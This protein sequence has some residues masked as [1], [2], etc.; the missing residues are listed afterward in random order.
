MTEGR[1]NKGK[2]THPAGKQAFLALPFIV[3]ATCKTILCALQDLSP[4]RSQCHLQETG[5]WTV[6]FWVSLSEAQLAFPQCGKRSAVQD[7][8]WDT[9]GSKISCSPSCLFAICPSYS[10]MCW[11]GNIWTSMKEFPSLLLPLRRKWKQHDHLRRKE[12]GPLNQ[13]N[14]FWY[15]VQGSQQRQVCLLVLFCSFKYWKKT[16]N[17]SKW[18]NETFA[19]MLANTNVINIYV[20]KLWWHLNRC[21]PMNINWSSNLATPDYF[22][23]REVPGPTCLGHSLR[24]CFCCGFGGWAPGQGAAAS[25]LH[26]V[27]RN[28][29]WMAL[30]HRSK[31]ECWY[32]KCK[33][34]ICT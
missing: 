16:Q 10:T 11:M 29:A 6:H 14:I 18:F 22:T 5:V 26:T 32:I 12:A 34:W 30:H 13:L 33:D 23:H 1:M 2:G 8:E 7:K 28:T 19:Y 20:S 27:S 3:T 24:G 9:K 25:L 4:G 15:K 21:F 31:P 17:R